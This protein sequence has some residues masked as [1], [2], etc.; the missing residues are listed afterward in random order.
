LRWFWFIAIN[1]CNHVIWQELRIWNLDLSRYIHGNV[2]VRTK[3][4]FANLQIDKQSARL[5]VPP[6]TDIGIHVL[7]A[8]EKVKRSEIRINLHDISSKMATFSARLAPPPLG[9]RP[10][11]HAVLHSHQS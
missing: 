9:S 3:A 1:S 8:A 7:I 2:H 11:Y 4:E 6:M 10:F 5:K